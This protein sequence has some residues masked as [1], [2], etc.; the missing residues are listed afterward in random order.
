VL[1]RSTG[2][3][4]PFLDVALC[5]EERQQGVNTVNQLIGAGVVN[6]KRGVIG[7]FANAT[8]PKLLPEEWWRSFM[9]AIE[10]HYGDY[11]I[12]EIVPAFG[13]SLLG[14]RYPAYYS[15]SIRR[16]S[17]TLSALSMF[18]SAD[19]GIMHLAS[20]SGVPTIGIFSVTSAEEWGPYGP[21]DR[22]V[23]AKD[24]TPVQTAQQVFA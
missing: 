13:R 22:V 24:Q 10:A 20:A 4:Y 19:C 23:H 1:Q 3:N 21:N 15:S 11:A 14:S 18:I 16:L 2:D 8:P 17:S 12:V 7:V 6:A 5:A 9:D